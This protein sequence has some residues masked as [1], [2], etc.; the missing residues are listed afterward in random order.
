MDEVKLKVEDIELRTLS[1]EEANELYQLIDKN[2]DQMGEWLLWVDKISSLE[3]AEKLIQGYIKSKE[4]G[5]RIHFG[6]WYQGKLIGDV[7]F[8]S[9]DKDYRKGSIGYWLDSNYHGKGIITKSCKRLIEYGFNELNLR[10]IEISCAEGNNK[11][12]AIPERLGFKEEGRFREAELI[13]GGKL[14]DSY[15]YALLKQDWKK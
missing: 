10:R 12:R 6:I 1:L 14:V 15:H 5:D 11:S 3:D 7:Y 4:A 9:I 2:S 8:S 13:R